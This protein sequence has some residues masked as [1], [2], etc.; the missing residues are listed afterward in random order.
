MKALVQTAL[1]IN[2]PLCPWECHQCLEDVGGRET[3]QLVYPLEG[4]ESVFI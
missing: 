1:G 3:V 2:E 4:V